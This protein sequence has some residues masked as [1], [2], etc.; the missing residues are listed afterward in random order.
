[1]LIPSSIES[2]IHLPVMPGTMGTLQ[3]LSVSATIKTMYFFISHSLAKSWRVMHGGGL[4]LM[5]H[6]YFFLL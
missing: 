1:M 2:S 6:D 5:R 4:M 3:P